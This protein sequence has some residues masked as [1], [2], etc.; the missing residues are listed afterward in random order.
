M[1]FLTRLRKKELIGSPIKNT[2]SKKQLYH[3]IF[4]QV[5]RL[6]YFYI[7]VFIYLQKYVFV[8]IL[9]VYYNLDKQIIACMDNPVYYL[10]N[11]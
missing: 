6:L 5:N 4:I 9:V 3:S 7:S 10:T 11:L 1:L 2:D 8:D